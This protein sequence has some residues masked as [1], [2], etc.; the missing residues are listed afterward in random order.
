MTQPRYQDI[1]AGQVALLA[2][3]NGGALLRV[4]AGDIDGH[5]GP[6]VTTPRL[7]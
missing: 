1:R 7:R 2:S 5:A 4:I 3:T 6:G